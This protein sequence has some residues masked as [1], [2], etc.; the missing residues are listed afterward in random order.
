MLNIQELRQEIKNLLLE[1][2]GVDKT[3]IDKVLANI[4]AT[5]A[6]IGFSLETVSIIFLIPSRS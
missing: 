1:V 2:T 5:L 4:A 3:T 6:D